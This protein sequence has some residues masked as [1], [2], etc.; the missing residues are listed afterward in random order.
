MDEE[1]KEM[2]NVDHLYHFPTHPYRFFVC[3]SDLIPKL[4]LKSR[5]LF[6]IDVDLYQSY[7]GRIVYIS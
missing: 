5:A 3:V 7:T 2:P 4:Y 6:Q 1:N